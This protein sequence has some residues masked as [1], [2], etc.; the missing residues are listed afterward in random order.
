MA[1]NAQFAAEVEQV[2]LHVGQALDDVVPEGAG[3]EHQADRAVG[4]IDGAVRLDAHVLFRHTCAV[5]EASAA[6]VTGTRVDLG[7]PIAH[8]HVAQSLDAEYAPRGVSLSRSWTTGCARA[9]AYRRAK[10][11]PKPAVL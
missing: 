9:G 8:D 3:R 4:L 1:R 5:S 10:C 11:T 2:V 7:Q 6:V